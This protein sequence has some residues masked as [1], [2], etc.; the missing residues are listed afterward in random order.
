MLTVIS[1]STSPQAQVHSHGN[2]GAVLTP[3]TERHTEPPGTHVSSFI[4]PFHFIYPLPYPIPSSLVVLFL[5]FPFPVLRLHSISS[6]SFLSFHSRLPSH[7][8]PF[9][10]LLLIFPFLP[11]LFLLS[12]FI[13]ILSLL[14]LLFILF[15]SF[16]FF[17][18]FVLFHFSHF[19]YFEY[20]SS[21]FSG[22][23]TEFLFVF[24]RH[25]SSLSTWSTHVPA[26]LFF[27]FSF[28]LF[29]SLSFFFRE[30]LHHLF[31]TY[32]FIPLLSLPSLFIAQFFT[33]YNFFSPIELFSCP[34]ALSLLSACCTLSF[35]PLAT[36]RLLLLIPL[37]YFL[38]LLVYPS[39][40]IP[41]PHRVHSRPRRHLIPAFFSSSSTPRQPTSFISLHVHI[42]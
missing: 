13:F 35:L 37:L 42:N 38:Y 15:L 33:A 36:Y 24:S 34:L 10:F 29:F 41:L 18:T 12:C 22:L 26:A 11:F 40:I 14:V 20:L 16:L 23:V 4:F 5:F 31:I 32:D 6:S 25:S 8:L 19:S 21:Q 39:Y 1:K 30:F 7:P 17:F 27:L 2:R 3:A 9:I 28:F